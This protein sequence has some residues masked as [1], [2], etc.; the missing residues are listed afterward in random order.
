MA[1]IN[2][3][4][5]N[6]LNVNEL[7]ENRLKI[8]DSISVSSIITMYYFDFT[9]DFTA[10]LEKHPFWEFVYVDNGSVIV[11]AENSTYV[12]NKGEIVFHK[13]DV[14]HSVC[15]DGK[16]PANIFIMTF[17][18]NNRAMNTFNNCITKLP[19]N[20][21]GILAAIIDE[22]KKS[23]GECP[24]II[25]EHPQAP[26]GA[27]QMI[28]SY[29]E[30]FLILIK[31]TIDTG[32]TENSYNKLLQHNN[33]GT[34][35]LVTHIIN[36]LEQNIYGNITIADISNRTNYGKNQLCETFKNV[37]GKTI[38]EYY[39]QLKINEAKFLMREQRLNNAQISD[40]LFFSSP[41]YFTKVF[42]SVTSM[43]PR[44][45]KASIQYIL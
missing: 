12:L 5:E 38:V 28:K 15:C 26:F 17:V 40:L 3:L 44:E 1:K 29:L 30:Q 27:E 9:A 36:I 20:L 7:Y 19:Y 42:K 31:R 22:M 25:C 37:T 21:Q 14:L 34:N 6:Q 4:H 11:T 23:Y 8:K 39:T 18:A 33:T 24:G 41:Q 13:P 10:P 32:N 43:T 45:Y 16:T 2:K 35:Q